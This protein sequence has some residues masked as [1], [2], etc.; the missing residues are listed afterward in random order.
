MS[1]IPNNLSTPDLKTFGPEIKPLAPDVPS[2]LQLDQNT[3]DHITNDIQNLSDNRVAIGETNLLYTQFVDELKKFL[4]E[5][6]D[7]VS[8]TKNKINETVLDIDTTLTKVVNSVEKLDTSDIDDALSTD[9]ENPVLDVDKNAISEVVSN[10]LK[11]LNLESIINK[12]IIQTAFA[13]RSI[14]D[15]NSVSFKQ[16]LD[17]ELTN[18]L[19][20][21]KTDESEFTSNATAL[22]PAKVPEEHD[23]IDAEFED[24]TEISTERQETLPTVVPVENKPAETKKDKNEQQNLV[25][26]QN[27]IDLQRKKKILEVDKK[28]GNI[29]DSLKKMIELEDVV[30]DYDPRHT[31]QGEDDK[32]SNN[33]P[34]VIRR[35]NEDSVDFNDLF[36]IEI[37]R[38]TSSGGTWKRKLGTGLLI[39]SAVTLLVMFRG[40]SSHTSLHNYINKQAQKKEEALAR[41]LN[42]EINHGE[43]KTDPINS[44]LAKG[45][46]DVE[47]TRIDVD[48]ANEELRAADKQIDEIKDGSEEPP[49]IE[50]LNLDEDEEDAEELKLLDSEIKETEDIFAEDEED[51]DIDEAVKTANEIVDAAQVESVA[52]N[53][54]LQQLDINAIESEALINNTLDEANAVVNEAAKELTEKQNVE[55]NSEQ[56]VQQAQPELNIDHNELKGI[57]DSKKEEFKSNSGIEQAI[58]TLETHV[59]E[60]SERTE[61]QLNEFEKDKEAIDKFSKDAVEDVDDKKQK[62]KEAQDKAEKEAKEAH[63]QIKDNPANESSA[64]K[65]E[66]ATKENAEKIKQRDEEV[67]KTAVPRKELEESNKAAE[68]AIATLSDSDS[69]ADEVNEQTDD[70]AKS[71]DD[72]NKSVSKIEDATKELNDKQLTLDEE[73]KPL[74]DV[75][76]KDIIV[77]NTETIVDSISDSDYDLE[78]YSEESIKIEIEDTDSIISETDEDTKKLDDATKDNSKELENIDDELKDVEQSNREL[79]NVDELL[80]TSFEQA[81]NEVDSAVETAEANEV[82]TSE[83]ESEIKPEEIVSEV[84][85]EYPIDESTKVEEASTEIEQSAEDEQQTIPT[86]FIEFIDN[87]INKLDSL[88]NKL[89][90]LVKDT[91]ESFEE[92]QEQTED[93]Q[94][95]ASDSEKNVLLE[96]AKSLN[97]QNT[98]ISKAI[99]LITELAP[100]VVNEANETAENITNVV[101]DI[102]QSVSNFNDA[103]IDNVKKS[104]FVGN[105]RQK[106]SNMKKILLGIKSSKLID[107]EN[108]KNLVK[109]KIT[110]AVQDSFKIDINSILSNKNEILNIFSDISDEKNKFDLFTKFTQS[111]QIIDDSIQSLFNSVQALDIRKIVDTL[112]LNSKSTIKKITDSSKNATDNSS[113]AKKSI[114]FLSSR[115][116]DIKEQYFELEKSTESVKNKS[117][118]NEQAADQLV[119]EKVNAPENLLEAKENVDNDTF[120]DDETALTSAQQNV[121]DSVQDVEKLPSTVEESDRQLNKEAEA[122]RNINEQEVIED[123]V[124]KLNNVDEVASKDIENVNEAI[125]ENNEKIE[126]DVDF[127]ISNIKDSIVE[128]TLSIKDAISKDILDKSALIKDEAEGIKEDVVGTVTNIKSTVSDEIVN[129]KK[130]VEETTNNIRNAAT[131]L[132]TASQTEFSEEVKEETEQTEETP[133][134]IKQIEDVE[135]PKFE[136]LDT[137]DIDSLQKSNEESIDKAAEETVNAS[138]VLDANTTEKEPTE[139]YVSKLEKQEE[140]VRPKTYIQVDKESLD[141]LYAQIREIRILLANMVMKQVSLQNR[142]DIN[143]SVQSM[144]RNDVRI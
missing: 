85:T 97:L 34:N 131:K 33:K 110:D 14:I 68:Q 62:T 83:I 130:K 59:N 116:S 124:Q 135:L 98:P 57:I 35:N 3:L 119:K 72:E 123:E 41:E 55:I 2:D 58:E 111:I 4:D 12:T 44:E 76:E 88:D 142:Q 20:I 114:D 21:I 118:E 121:D 46:Q 65:L 27:K 51:A 132:F 69:K 71:Q 28:L 105:I 74:Q 101:N 15:A 78:Q 9:I 17:A 10:V 144:Y 95:K 126:K 137:S 93:L 29:N 91:N 81:Q 25:E 94:E 112:K 109:D 16:T 54:Q 107:V 127:S 53:D 70:A 87:C 60:F 73:L 99:Q 8:D 80:R 117:D 141:K 96:L 125:D 40:Y 37:I 139:D 120:K 49:P 129:T 84:E 106:I 48:N 75:N 61:A 42:G 64:K 19:D 140:Y 63:K 56:E 66:D 1:D 128:K 6:A 32:G 143:N 23:Y 77:E 90:D 5:K 43:S 45:E 86:N 31:N 122:E 11:A 52:I 138:K 38:P 89:S 36:D 136:E 22:L 134:A 92:V 103:A 113:L 47:S 133:E 67:T 39:G 24:I 100:S 115:L 30:E 7:E 18:K 108:I 102:K 26:L 50:D 79:S 82:E 104:A 13:I